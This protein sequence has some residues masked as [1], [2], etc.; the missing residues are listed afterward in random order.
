VANPSLTSTSHCIIVRWPGAHKT[1]PTLTC[2]PCARTSALCLY[3]GPTL[4]GPAPCSCDQPCTCTPAWSLYDQPHA[5]TSA[6]H[7]YD[8]PCDCLPTHM[9]L[10][11]P[12]CLRPR[13]P[14]YSYSL[15][16]DIVTMVT[17]HYPHYDILM[18]I[19][20]HQQQGSSFFPLWIPC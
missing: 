9:F 2:Q 13:W 10:K 14:L 8:Q 19:K 20:A 6:L 16:F 4:V 18:Y 5:C 12:N 1:S 15:F 7:L 17:V 11:S 3:I